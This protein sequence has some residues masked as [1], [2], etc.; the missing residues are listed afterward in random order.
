MQEKYTEEI[1]E[2]LK[3]CND[4]SLL[5]FIFQLLRKQATQA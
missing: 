5:D 1:V 3:N 4:V 2:L